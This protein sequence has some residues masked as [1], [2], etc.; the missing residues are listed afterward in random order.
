MGGQGSGTWLRWSKKQ[1]VEASLTLE[2]RDVC[3]KIPP[4]SSGLLAWR[5]A[6]GNSFSVSYCTR[7][8]GELIIT[9]SYRWRGSERVELPIRM[10]STA[11]NF[12]GRRWWF[13]CPLIVGGVACERRVGKLYLPPGAKYF[14]CRRCHDL[15]YESSQQAHQWERWL[16]RQDLLKERFEGLEV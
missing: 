15:T 2:V 16:A 5:W 10:Q 8:C 6:L 14:G 7:W 12:D 1:T 11:T 3:S 13:T 9:L 4:R